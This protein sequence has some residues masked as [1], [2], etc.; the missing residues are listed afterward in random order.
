MHKRSITVYYAM[1]IRFR[2]RFAIC[3]S[4]YAMWPLTIYY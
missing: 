4:G 2:N 3:P 1:V